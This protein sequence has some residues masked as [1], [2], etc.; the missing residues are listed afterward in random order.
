[1]LILTR[2]LRRL[3]FRLPPVKLSGLHRP[4]QNPED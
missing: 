2:H 4:R 3:H 1:M